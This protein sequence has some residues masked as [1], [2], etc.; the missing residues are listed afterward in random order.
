MNGRM[1]YF[2]W[3]VKIIFFVELDKSI[4]FLVIFCN[5]IL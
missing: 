2:D 5:F 4:Y 3:K 1:G